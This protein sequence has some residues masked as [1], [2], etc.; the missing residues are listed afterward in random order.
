MKYLIL[1]ILLMNIMVFSRKHLSRKSRRTHGKDYEI[2]ITVLDEDPRFKGKIIYFGHAEI[3]LPTTDK[4]LEIKI[5]V[6]NAQDQNLEDDSAIETKSEGTMGVIYKLPFFEPVAEGYMLLI[7]RLICGGGRC[8]IRYGSDFV[9][10]ILQITGVPDSEIILGNDIRNSYYNILSKNFMDEIKNSINNLMIGI[11]DIEQIEKDYGIKKQELACMQAIRNGNKF[12]DMKDL[13]DQRRERINLLINENLL[14]GFDY[15]VEKNDAIQSINE[16]VKECERKWNKYMSLEDNTIES[17]KKF[18]IELG[19]RIFEIILAH[20]GVANKKYEFYGAIVSEFLY[21]YLNRF[22][23]AEFIKAIQDQK[24]KN[25][26]NST[27]EK[28]KT[29]L[30]Y[31]D[32]SKDSS[33]FKPGAP[34][35]KTS[36][37]VVSLLMRE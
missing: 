7:R 3:E 28:I 20:L 37:G 31:S 14:S 1:L 19:D 26:L 11:E 34:I 12:Y 4:Q 27:L 30:Y 9:P 32:F 36:P 15:K 6:K 21:T 35:L 17:E 25:I 23:F 29:Y 2:K 13:Y 18:H 10:V 8:F 5:I 16:L 22:Y 33:K 24:F